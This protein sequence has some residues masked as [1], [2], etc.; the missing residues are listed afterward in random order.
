[1]LLNRQNVQTHKHIIPK[2]IPHRTNNHNW[3]ARQQHTEN[4]KVS[5]EH[6]HAHR[7]VRT[8]FIRLVSRR[9][10]TEAAIRSVLRH[11]NIK[12]TAFCTRFRNGSSLLRT[13]IYTLYSRTLS[14]NTT[15]SISPLT[16]A[17]HIL[18][19][20]L[21]HENNLRTFVISRNSRHFTSYLHRTVITHTSTTIPTYPENTATHVGHSFLLRRVTTDFINVIH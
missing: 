11:S 21:S 10:C 5:G 16:R 4:V 1:M 18:R 7:T 15:A 19:G 13:R 9:N 20:L 14:V 17:R 2:H 8:T 6:R 3:H 12:H